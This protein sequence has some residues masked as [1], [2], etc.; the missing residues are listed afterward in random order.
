[1]KDTEKN[2]ETIVG[3][4]HRKNMGRDELNLAEFPLATLADKVPPDCKTLVFGDRIWDRSQRKHIARRLTIAASDKYGLPTAL[5]DD[6]I[7][8]LVQL[9]KAAD[10]A[11]RCVRFSR[12]QLIRLLGWRDEGKS[13]SRL[14]TSLKRWLG[15]TLYYENAWWDKSRKKWVDAHFHLLDN[16]VLYRGPRRNTP[17]GAGGKEATLSAFTWNEVV[18][19]SFQAGYLKQLDMELYRALHR[20]TAKRMYRFLDKR[21]HFSNH[22]RFD[23]RRFACEHVGLSRKYDAAQLKRRLHPAIEEL[24][25]AGYLEPLPASDRFCRMRRGEW[26]VTFLRTSR[27]RS[28]NHANRQPTMVEKQLIDRGVTATAAAR[29]AREYPRD[30]IETK[31]DVFD[32]L[33]KRGDKRVSR[34]PAGYLVKSIRD[35]YSTPAGIKENAGRQAVPRAG[36]RNGS[37]A[38]LV[39]LEAA[40]KSP[41]TQEEEQVHDYLLHLSP[42]ERS[43]LE[44]ESLNVAS[45]IAADGLQRATKSGNQGMV[46][47]Y[48][49]AIVHQYVR[50]RL[51]GQSPKAQHET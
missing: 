15:V 7:L 40:S 35:D 42:G 29:L 24:E 25:Q 27:A 43:Q 34:N 14:E 18:F 30:V 44:R 51:H 1:M 49:Q 23:L 20:R 39:R 32:T 48:R 31:I 45:R 38:S 3:Q 50:S 12:Y 36:G 6:V 22:V 41:S 16:L 11:D 33:R 2:G 13:Y 9:S 5:D 8:G 10:F 17:A 37:G 21:F 46:A 19:H 4:A 47:H 26:Q 28:R